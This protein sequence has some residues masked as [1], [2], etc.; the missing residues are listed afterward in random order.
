MKPSNHLLPLL[1]VAA[2]AAGCSRGVSTGNP[3]DTSARG[4]GTGAPARADTPAPPVRAASLAGSGWKLASYSI[5]RATAVANDPRAAR[6]TLS[7]NDS[8][9]CGG[10]TGCNRFGGTYRADSPAVGQISFG[11]LMMTKMYCPAVGNFETMY[12]AA[13]SG[14][15]GYNLV[16]DSLVLRVKAPAGDSAISELRFVRAAE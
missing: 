2:I 16:A 6:A 4:T 15:L 3:A 14:S 13:L 5:G 8:A 10:N 7:F 1:L 9:R 12:A 11:P